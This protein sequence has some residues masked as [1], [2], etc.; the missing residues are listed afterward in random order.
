MLLRGVNPGL[1]TQL[2]PGLDDVL[3]RFL[4][5]DAVCGG[6]AALAIARV[7]GRAELPRLRQAFDEASDSI[8]RV[9]TALALCV[10]DPASYPTLA[11][12]LRANVGEFYAFESWLA[13]DVLD[14]LRGV[15]HPEATALAESLALTSAHPTGD[16]GRTRAAVAAL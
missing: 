3:H 11:P 15:G 13:R 16:L 14:I 9:F 5:A 8:E 4:S 6:Q 1:L 7:S 10:A 12:V 2:L